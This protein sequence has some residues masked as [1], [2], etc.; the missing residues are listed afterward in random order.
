MSSRPLV[1][2]RFYHKQNPRSVSRVKCRLKMAQIERRE[3]FFRI[4][5]SFSIN[6]RI[7]V[8]EAQAEDLGQRWLEFL[9]NDMR[10]DGK[11]SE[12]DN[13]YRSKSIKSDAFSLVILALNFFFAVSPKERERER[14]TQ[15]EKGNASETTFT[16]FVSSHHD[17]VEEKGI[18]SSR[19]R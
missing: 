16:V 4:S 12:L 18:Q 7:S 13:W 6:S 15:T 19:E 2:Y 14:H 3:S 17:E 9:L 8:W 5:K 10:I 1:E 11:Q